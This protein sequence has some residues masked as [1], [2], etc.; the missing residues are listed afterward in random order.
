MVRADYGGDGA[1]TTFDG[2]VIDVYDDWR[3]KAPI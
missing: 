3:I 1:A 2:I